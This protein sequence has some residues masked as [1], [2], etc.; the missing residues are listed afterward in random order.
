[1]LT[2]PHCSM[3]KHSV[4]FCRQR[5]NYVVK[6]A[7]CRAVLG[8]RIDLL[9]VQ[10]IESWGGGGWGRGGVGWAWGAVD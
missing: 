6:H 9:F 7:V 3:R 10:E 2:L 5:Q 8:S 4:T 1:M